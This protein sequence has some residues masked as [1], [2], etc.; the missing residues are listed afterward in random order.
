GRRAERGEDRVSNVGEAF[1]VRVEQEGQAAAAEC[2]CEVEPEVVDA[3]VLREEQERARYRQPMG[4]ATRVAGGPPEGFERPPGS[5]AQYG[6]AWAGGFER[7]PGTA[8]ETA[9]PDDTGPSDTGP[10]DTAP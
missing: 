3:E 4:T 7:A 6:H 10:N 8:A 2:V 1:P 9:A 5:D